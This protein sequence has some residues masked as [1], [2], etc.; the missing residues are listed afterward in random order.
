MSKL[1][2]TPEEKESRERRVEEQRLL[3]SRAAIWL[4]LRTEQEIYDLIHPAL[5]MTVPKG[6]GFDNLDIIIYRGLLVAANWITL[7]QYCPPPKPTSSPGP[8]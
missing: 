7:S 4:T 2:E 1:F 3:Y 6:H 8:P 5:N